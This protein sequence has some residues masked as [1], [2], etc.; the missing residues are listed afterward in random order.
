M[1]KL[2]GGAEFRLLAGE[3]YV[4]DPERRRRAVNVFVARAGGASVFV[5]CE[6]A[7]RE[8]LFITETPKRL[9][10][11]PSPSTSVCTAVR[12]NG[13]TL[14]EHGSPLFGVG[15]ETPVYVVRHDSYEFRL[16]A[17]QNEWRL[18]AVERFP[19]PY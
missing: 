4:T 6:Q 5:N 2:R 9:L 14:V 18:L 13:P 11:V 17:E 16:I 10:D 8:Q 15:E 7:D 12:K 3:F 19:D 1:R